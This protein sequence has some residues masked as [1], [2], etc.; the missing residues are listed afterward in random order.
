MNIYYTKKGRFVV[1]KNHVIPIKKLHRE[2]GP[3]I[4]TYNCCLHWFKNG[5][6]HREDGPAT[7]YCNGEREFWLNYQ[8]LNCN[9]IE[10]WI[11]NN[12]I[13]L[14]TKKGKVLFIMNFIIY[15]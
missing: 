8:M 6:L 7:I 11:K 1:K 9:K 13:D 12:N 15:D 2:D 3:A 5:K 4:I 14:S 10:A